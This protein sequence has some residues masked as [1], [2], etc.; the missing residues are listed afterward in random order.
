[1][2][3]HRPIGSVIG[4]SQAARQP[5]DR[6]L[7]DPAESAQA[8]GVRLATLDDRRP[9]ATLPQESAVLVVAVAA[10]GEEHVRPPARSAD[11]YGHGRDP[12]QQRQ[13]LG[14][15]VAVSAGQR[16]SSSDTI[17]GR[18]R[19]FPMTTSTTDQVDSHMIKIFC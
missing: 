7:G 19:R 11:D 2:S 17:H 10:V 8:S 18:D 1:M 12:V 14:G 16:H 9:D 13:K 4:G 15:V 6:P 3:S 5:G